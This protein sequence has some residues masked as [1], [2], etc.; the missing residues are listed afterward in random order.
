MCV[1]VSIKDLNAKRPYNYPETIIVLNSFLCDFEFFIMVG[2][3]LVFLMDQ[4][5]DFCRV[6][7]PGNTSIEWKEASSVRCI[8]PE[9]LSIALQPVE[10]LEE[11]IRIESYSNSTKRSL[12]DRV[13]SS[14]S[15]INKKESKQ[16]DVDRE[17]TKSSISLV[18]L[19][20]LVFFLG[21][22]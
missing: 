8:S 12:K 2:Y 7:P 9:N 18:I 1:K 17:N 14:S 13:R 19:E 3:I 11:E 20:T 21:K 10:R 6:G 5:G 22:Q 15:V 16:L 4:S